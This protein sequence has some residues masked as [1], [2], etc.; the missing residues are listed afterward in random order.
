ML[1]KTITYTDYND[2]TRTEKFYFNLTK[3]ELTQMNFESSCGFA[4]YIKAIV[5]AKNVVE[6]AALFKRIIDMSY[7]VKSMDGKQ[8]IKNQTVLDE[9]R[10]SEAYNILYME[11]VTDDE[12]AANFING[13]LPKDLAEKAKVEQQ[14][15]LS[16]TE[17]QA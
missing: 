10:Q 8:F 16:S 1:T 3:S 7:G 2:V 15:L 14:K 11:L 6:V 17:T 9:F 13:I 4:D 12:V 5:D